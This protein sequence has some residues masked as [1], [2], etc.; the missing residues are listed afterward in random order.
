MVQLI[1]H[2]FNK[3]SLILIKNRGVGSDETSMFGEVKN[4]TVEKNPTVS[5]SFIL[6]NIILKY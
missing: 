4:K 5:V 6:V 1:R 2:T 3:S